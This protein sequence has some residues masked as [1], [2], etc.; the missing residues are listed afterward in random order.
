M[1]KEFL[2][3]FPKNLLFRPLVHLARAVFSWQ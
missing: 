1:K 3:V 2:R